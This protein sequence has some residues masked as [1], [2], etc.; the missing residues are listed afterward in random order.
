MWLSIPS[1]LARSAKDQPQSYPRPPLERARDARKPATRRA[2]AAAAPRR[3]LLAPTPL[4]G[5]APVR[6][7]G[8]GIRRRQT[9]T[10]DAARRSIAHAPAVVL[11]R[12]AGAR[13]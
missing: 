13:Q 1:V 7:A 12:A 10:P 5:G 2:V 4:A 9:R 6:L 11:G 3:L 8:R